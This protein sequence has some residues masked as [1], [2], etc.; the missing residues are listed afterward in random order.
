MTKHPTFSPTPAWAGGIESIRLAPFACPVHFAGCSSSGGFSLA[1]PVTPALTSKGI[2]TC[3]RRQHIGGPFACYF[4]RR[5]RT[6]PINP[7]DKR[8]ARLRGRNSVPSIM[9]RTAPIVTRL[10]QLQSPRE[11]FARIEGT[12]QEKLGPKLGKAS[13]RKAASSEN[14]RLPRKNRRVGLLNHNP[15]PL[16]SRSSFQRSARPSL[17]CVGRVPSPSGADRHAIDA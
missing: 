2:E 9:R 13:A 5:Q 3:D 17:G 7:G 14:S 11:S 12:I 15:A 16:P 6:P 1:V 8:A 10:K 4:P